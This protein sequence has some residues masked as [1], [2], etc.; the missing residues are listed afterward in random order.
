M[1]AALLCVSLSVPLF[2]TPPAPHL[3]LLLFH[4][5]HFGFFEAIH[6]NLR[7]ELG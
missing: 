6:E 7:Q 2:I 3:P 5:Q 4:T 1:L